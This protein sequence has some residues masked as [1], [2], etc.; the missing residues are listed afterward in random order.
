M[1]K[2][3]LA[4]CGILSSITFPV[5]LLLFG[6]ITPGYNH[7]EQA[8][9]ELGMSNAPYATLWNLLGFE[10]AGILMFVFA[11]SLYLEFESSS[12]GRI[13]AG[14]VALSGLGFAGLGIFP[15]AIDFQPSRETSLHTLMMIV[16]F[17]SFI[18][19]SFVFGV[20]LRSDSRWKG[21]SRFSMVMGVIGLL[22]FAIP[23]SVPVG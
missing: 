1:L 21:W 12:G 18:M 5:M 13:I 3:Y 9:S 16:S 15:A 22:S 6:A 11:W 17:F 23:R 14:L 10:L 20:K 4:L 2:K 8:V 7:L 19:V